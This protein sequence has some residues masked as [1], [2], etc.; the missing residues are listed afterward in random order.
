[1]AFSNIHRLITPILRIETIGYILILISVLLIAN[2]V[3]LDKT[4]PKPTPEEK[5]LFI[6][7]EN[8]YLGRNGCEKN[9]AKTLSLYEEASKIRRH[10]RAVGGMG[11]IYLFVP[12]FKNIPL[13]IEL[14]EEAAKAGDYIACFRMSDFYSIEA[15]GHANADKAIKYGLMALEISPQGIRSHQ[16]LSGAY[17]LAGQYD[18]AIEHQEY[19]VG[20]YPHVNNQYHQQAKRILEEYKSHL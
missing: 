19:I 9:V 18:K 5:A 17:E 11:Q 7:A 16:A 12:G 6:Q 2:T 3:R 4:P 13:G 1:M 10:P 14:T 15:L 20:H 8:Y